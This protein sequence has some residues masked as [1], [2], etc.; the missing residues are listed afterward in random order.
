MTS[1]SADPAM[2]VVEEHT[3][4]PGEEGI[5]EVSEVEDFSEDEIEAS[6]GLEDPD[7]RLQAEAHEED[8]CDQDIT[9]S[10]NTAS[11]QHNCI[12]VVQGDAPSKNTTR[13]SCV[14]SNQIVLE[15]EPG[16]ERSVGCVTITTKKPVLQSAGGSSWRVNEKE[17]TLLRRRIAEIVGGDVHADRKKIA[18]K[19]VVHADRILLDEEILKIFRDSGRL[20]LP[21]VVGGTEVTPEADAEQDILER[22]SSGELEQKD[23]TS[24][25]TAGPSILQKSRKDALLDGPL[26]VDPPNIP[27]MN[28]NSNPQNSHA[29]PPARIKLKQSPTHKI[30]QQQQLRDNILL[31]LCRHIN[32][33]LEWEFTTDLSKKDQAVLWRDCF[34]K[35]LLRKVV[36]QRFHRGLPETEEE[37]EDEG[38]GGGGGTGTG[39]SNKPALKK[40]KNMEELIHLKKSDVDVLVG[41]TA[42]DPCVVFM[43]KVL[44]GHVGDVPLFLR[45]FPK[46][47]KL[48]T[49]SGCNQHLCYLSSVATTLNTT[50]TSPTTPSA[51]TQTVSILDLLL[52]KKDPESAEISQQD[53]LGDLEQ[54]FSDYEY[55]HNDE[56]LLQSRVEAILQKRVEDFWSS[57]S[58]GGGFVARGCGAIDSKLVDTWQV[59]VKGHRLRDDEDRDQNQ[60]EGGVTTVGG[61][62]PDVHLVQNKAGGKSG[63]PGAP[64][65]A[66]QLIPPPKGPPGMPPHKGAP[67]MGGN[68]NPLC[69]RLFSQHTSWEVLEGSRECYRHTWRERAAPDHR[70]TCNLQARVSVPAPTVR[71]RPLAS[72]E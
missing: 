42:S 29:K 9:A 27:N 68:P 18:E 11:G 38:G 19:P 71:R 64:P 37:D 30:R 24:P 41:E 57:G 72:E 58:A 28:T 62:R 5:H 3:T 56:L 48:E 52:P 60:S 21:E 43:K 31:V 33:E 32:S 16:I 25:P 70:R 1:P 6:E 67:A 35:A 45:L 50:T 47:F 22:N 13:S 7:N 17:Q 39:T 55:V 15:E 49:R 26:Q 12:G 65:P 34:L 63:K 69:N 10:K 40:R 14:D 8:F 54:A 53:K 44:G 51:Q 4:A 46:L 36:Y 23:A 59:T 66:P 20:P 61:H 2:V